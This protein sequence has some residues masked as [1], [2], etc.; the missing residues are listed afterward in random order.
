MRIENIKIR[1]F[2]KLKEVKIDLR[3]DKTVFIG[4]NNSGKTSAM[5]AMRYFLKTESKSF[6]IYDFTISNH[7]KIKEIGIKL[8]NETDKSPEPRDLSLW[9]DILPSFDIWFYVGDDDIHYVSHIIPTL[10]WAGG[11]LGVRLQYEP[12]DVAVLYSKYKEAHERINELKEKTFVNGEKCDTDLFPKDMF[13]FLEQDLQQYFT[14]KFYILDPAKK[15]VNQKSLCEPIEENP[16]VGLIQINEINAQRGLNDE[17]KD[18]DQHR[19]SKQLTEYYNLHLDPSKNPTEPEDIKA[20]DAIYKA[21]D[22][23]TTNM[24]DWFLPA[25][26][27]IGNLGYPGFYNPNI[28]IN[29]QLKPTDGLDHDSALQYELDGCN[30]S[31]LPETYNGLGYQNLIFI[32]FKLIRFRDSWLK[33]GKQKVSQPL[34]TNIEYPPIH[35]VLIEEPEAHLHPQAQQVFIKQAYKILTSKEE[36]KTGKLTTQ[37]VVTTHSS[38][39]THEC[40]FANLRYFKRIQPVAGETQST[41]VMN[42]SSVFRDDKDTEKFV[43]RYIKVTHCDLF[44]SDA[45]IL[46][47]GDAER[48]LLPHF[49]RK[50]SRLNQSYISLLSIGGSHAHKLKPFIETLG[51]PTLIIT[52]L[53][54]TKEIEEE[55]K[56]KWKSVPVER[57]KSQ[58]TNNDTLKLWFPKKEN[59]DD[60]LAL[61]S[62]DKKQDIP[63]A[64]RVAFQTPIKIDS[65]EVLPY[66]FED[67]LFFENKAIFDGI[68]NIKGMI[69]KVKKITNAQNAFDIIR[70]NGFKKA[71]FALDL[72]YLQNFDNI[73]IPTYISEGLQ[74]LENILQTKSNNEANNAK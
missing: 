33:I 72:L 28:T 14:I 7:V 39:I 36:I 74:W 61:S 63:Y 40:E 25:L 34:K 9:E 54:A 17:I 47:E 6:N 26:K 59:I 57:K 4:A 52:D 22:V 5:V 32:A 55:G 15:D 21:Q 68:K 42:L 38:H 24:R 51:I 62:E 65:S 3:D 10:D 16:L 56:K 37:L 43:S 29:P 11:Y 23:F 70:N 58:K 44:F 45:A 1:N 31:F 66:T 53:D 12:K 8:E 46:I 41:N 67:S 18:N 20:L 13:A 48:I 49:L 35:L 71:E 27:E 19:L 60:L 2:R 30:D 50:I 69:G 73:K 64:L